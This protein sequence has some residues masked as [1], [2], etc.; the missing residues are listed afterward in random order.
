MDS[1]FVCL[2]AGGAIIH[3]RRSRL[4][5]PICFR[6]AGRRRRSSDRCALRDGMRKV[7]SACEV[8]ALTRAIVIGPSWSVCSPAMS[9]CLLYTSDA[10]DEEDSVDLGGRRII[11]KKRSEEKQVH[12]GV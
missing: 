5:L 12:Q 10:A 9:P 1:R 7:G 2:Q 4:A 11:K 8:A 6:Q 3:V